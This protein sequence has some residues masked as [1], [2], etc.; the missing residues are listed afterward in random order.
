M[1][2]VEDAEVARRTVV[3]PATVRAG[4]HVRRRG[5]DLHAG[6]VLARAGD[7]LTP[8]ALRTGLR[9]RRN[10]RRAPRARGC[11]WS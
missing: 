6:D 5:E 8:A 10:G 1:L 7:V 11:T 9:G 4:L 3:P 2:R